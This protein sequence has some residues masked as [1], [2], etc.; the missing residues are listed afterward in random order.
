MRLAFFPLAFL[1]AA[2]TTSADVTPPTEHVRALQT[3]STGQLIPVGD[4]SLFSDSIT[5]GVLGPTFSKVESPAGPVPSALGSTSVV[6]STTG[7][8]F[9][10]FDATVED[11]AGFPLGMPTLSADQS[12]SGEVKVTL[13]FAQPISAFGTYMQV[14]DQYAYLC[15]DTSSNQHSP[16]PMCRASTPA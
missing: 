3:T 4:V 9:Y 16:A 7:T 5:W 1:V 11:F 2:S 10:R 14:G 8:Q 13:D 15:L 6:V 12:N